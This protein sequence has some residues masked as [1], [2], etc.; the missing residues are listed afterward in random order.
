MQ[1]YRT[2]LRVGETLSI[3]GG[4][5]VLTMEA[6]SGQRAR[7]TFSSEDDVRFLKS[8]PGKTGAVHAAQGIKAAGS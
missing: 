4:R 2:D 8:I 3:D 6:K 1:T 7:L 5:I